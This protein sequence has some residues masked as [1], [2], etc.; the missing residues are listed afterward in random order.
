MSAAEAVLGARSIHA[1][2]TSG[3]D[4]ATKMA[5]SGGARGAVN[6]VNRGHREGRVVTT[7]PVEHDHVAIDRGTDQAADI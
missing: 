7:H 5:P 1:S 2:M 6:L 4:Q 3:G